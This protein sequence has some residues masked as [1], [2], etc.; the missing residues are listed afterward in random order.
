MQLIYIHGLS[1]DHHSVKGQWLQ[2][3]CAHNRPDIVVQRPNLNLPPSEVMATL[4]QLIAHD[5]HTALVGSS[6]GGFYAT[7]CVAKWGLR[8]ALLNPSVRP[9]DSMQRFFQHGETRHATETG[10]VITPDQLDDLKQL[11]QPVPVHAERLMVLLK[12]GDEVLDYQMALSHYSQKGA[13]SIM[14]VEPGG[15]HFYRDLQDKIPLIMA[16][17]FS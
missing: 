11:Y 13:Q 3:W 4:E 7:A 17:L 1:A 6:L 12:E 8:A 16:F 9:F 5:V 14:Y 15:D 10:W 2:D